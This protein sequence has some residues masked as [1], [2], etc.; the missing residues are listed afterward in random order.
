[1]YGVGHVQSAHSNLG[2]VRLP[3]QALSSIK[4]PKFA[5]DVHY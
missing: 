4:N 1:M 3:R 5:Y 2:N